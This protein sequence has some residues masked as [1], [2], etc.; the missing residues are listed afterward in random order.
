MFLSVLFPFDRSRGLRGQVVED[1]VD[2]LDLA[3]D[4]SGDVLQEREGDVL[5]R[6]GHRVFGVDG[7]DNDRPFVGAHILFDARGLEIGDQREILPN[8]AFQTV[9]RKFLANAS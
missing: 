9:L 5:N 2:A 6:C 1:A 4:A 7:A 8:L 3:R